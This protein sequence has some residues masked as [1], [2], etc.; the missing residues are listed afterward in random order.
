MSLRYLLAMLLLCGLFSC[1]KEEAAIV[2]PAAGTATFS[3]VEMG[4]NY[5]KQLFYD[6]ATGKAIFSS[7]HADWDLAFDANP[8]GRDIYLNGGQGI[9]QGAQT[10][11]IY[12]THDTSLSTVTNLP[13]GM[14][15]NNSNGWH[16]DPVCYLAGQTAVGG[17][18]KADGRSKG[19]VYLI[20]TAS[21]TQK[22]RILSAD[23]TAYVIEWQPLYN[24]T[25][26]QV[27]LPKDSAYNFVYF[28]F[29][30]GIVHPEPP[31]TAWD[32]VFTRYRD[33][34]LDDKYFIMIPYLVTGVLTNPYRTTA[35][36]DSVDDFSAIDLAKA[37]SLPLY[38]NRNVIGW[39]WKSYGLNSTGLYTV[40]RH[41]NY[42]I[43]T[44]KGQLYKMHF[45]DFYS[46]S[47]QKGTPSF[48]FER[49]K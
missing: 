8:D 16:F 7:N 31:K 32:V 3:S 27:R 26:V 40:N 36:A 9:G 25:A 15:A 14:N 5:D 13:Q 12:N 1:E 28:A 23:A 6:L 45:L 48:E 42:V 43:S 22:F 2:L 44:Q 35:A 4:V 41:K 34:L 30:K 47:G 39:N 49:L 24:G 20:Q 38:P 46:A 11:C 29:D 19:E 18:W 17:W 21:G 10:V 37:Q 33:S